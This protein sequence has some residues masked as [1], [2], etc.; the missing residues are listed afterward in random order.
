[1]NNKN[2]ITM[3]IKDKIIYRGWLT[4]NERLLHKKRYEILIKKDAVAA[5]VEDK[6]KQ[7]LLVKQFRPALLR[8]TWEIPAGIMDKDGLNKKT[9]IIKELLEEADMKIT[10]KRLNFLISFI[11]EMGISNNKIHLYYA[12]LNYNGL[13]KTITKD[14]NVTANKWFSHKEIEQ[15]ISQGNLLDIKTLFAYYYYKN[16]HINQ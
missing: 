13:N 3:K 6:N 8:E 12:K 7:I 9:T 16:K 11:P 2:N 10:E 4:L 5:L 14:L 1:M 15:K